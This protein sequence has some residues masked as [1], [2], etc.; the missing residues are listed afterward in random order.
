MRPMGFTP[1]NTPEFGSIEDE[2]L[3][4][5]AACIADRLQDEQ[6]NDDEAIADLIEHLALPAYGS[7]DNGRCNTL[8]TPQLKRS[9][10]FVIQL[11]N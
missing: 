6:H 4:L 9:P 10:N 3:D 1:D 11:Q 8:C 2:F 7:A 5:P